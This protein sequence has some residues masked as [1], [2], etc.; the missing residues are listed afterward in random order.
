MPRKV[1]EL[2][3]SLAKA[4][5]IKRPAKGSHTFWYHPALPDVRITLSGKDGDDAQDY[6]AKFVQKALKRLGGLR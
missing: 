3:A 6:Q 5:F 4:G 1:R 2:K